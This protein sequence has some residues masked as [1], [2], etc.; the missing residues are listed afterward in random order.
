V[1]I[2]QMWLCSGSKYAFFPFCVTEITSLIISYQPIAV[3][4]RAQWW[5]Q[6]T[7]VQSL[8]SYFRRR[9]VSSWNYWGENSFCL[10]CLACWCHAKDIASVARGRVLHVVPFLSCLGPK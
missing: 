5:P 10:L 2:L 7:C 3:L 8:A 9:L 6:L 4:S 1:L